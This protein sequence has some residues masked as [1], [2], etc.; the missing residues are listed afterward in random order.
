[1]PTSTWMP[2]T[3]ESTMLTSRI[4][5]SVLARNGDQIVSFLKQNFPQLVG[6]LDAASILNLAMTTSPEAVLALVT[7]GDIQVSAN[8]VFKS[9]GLKNFT[10]TDAQAEVIH[11]A[12]GASI[13]IVDRLV[14]V[15]FDAPNTVMMPIQG[16]H[17]PLMIGEY[18]IRAM[19]IDTL[20]NVGSYAEPT[21]LRVVMPEA[22][23][24]SV[25]AASIGDRNGD[26]DADEPYESGTIYSNTTDGVMLTITVDH[27]SPHPA[28]IWAEYRG[29]DRA[30]HPIGEAEMFDEGVGED[31]STFEV[32]WDVT[33]FEALVSAG[34]SVMVRAVS[35][36]ALEIPYASEPFSIKLDAGVHP[37]DLEVLAVV[38]DT[39]SITKTNPDSG[40]P[41]GTV[42]IN[43]YTPQRT[44]PEIASLKLMIDDEVVG[45]ADTGVLATEEEIAALQ[46]N[47]DFITDLVAVA[48]EATA[49]DEL[50][51]KP[52]HYPTYLKWSVEVDTT[53]LEDTITAESAAARDASKD[54]NQYMV[55]A[56][57]ITSGAEEVPGRPGAKTYLSVDNVDDVAP[58]GPTTIVAVADVAG[59]IEADADGNY[60]VGG[61]VD[62]TVPTPIAIYT[63]EPTADP[64]TY[65]SIQLVQVDA[66]GNE[67][68]IDGEAGM[69]DITTDVGVLENGAYMLH[70]L[71]VDEF[72]NVQT[73]ES[74][75][76]TVHVLNFRVSD[77]T[78]LKVTAVDSVDV[79]RTPQ[80]P[81][82]LRSS[83]TVGF[84]V[85]NGSLD[86]AELS[87]SVDGS[88]VPTESD[89]DP[90]NTFSLMVNVS[91]LAD[92]MYTPNAVVTK[93]N[94]SVGFPLKEINLDNTGPMVEIQTPSED[95]TVDSLPT[96]HATYTDGEGSG[97]DST[98]KEVLAWATTELPAGPTVG[99]TRIL[100]EQGDI[101]VAVDQRAIETDNGT[102]VYTR[103]EKLG[104]GAYRITVRVADIL[105]NVGEATREFA[106]RRHS[107]RHDT[108]SHH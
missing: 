101:D 49:M 20:F 67:T 46:Q 97:T 25:T 74:P 27:R 104:G 48:A 23:K 7:P 57:A 73:D 5:T 79:P 45:T 59:M 108:A 78:Q 71:A 80:E 72:G 6:G 35:K 47:T 8:S 30:W 85:D 77:V 63:T 34:D 12:L 69:L 19:G 33:D 87:G 37:V 62:E 36:N 64:S 90:E 18:G 66:D 82:P 31:G 53:A 96:V 9:L 100:P 83:L 94:G 106:I 50:S 105:G 13:D 3:I 88:E 107:G 32:N 39:E 14:P 4:W 103:T 17:M 60:T 42:V 10:L 51:G 11:Q 26:G 41:Q 81:I 55:N 93:R 15:T 65:A 92:G 86:A 54:D 16:A 29:A 61:I 95:H 75:Q 1:M 91:E 24:A 98:G 21:R 40:G 2:L 68:M 76:I 84:N 38:L 22:D 89:E 44:Y 102:L 56:T 43:G 99:I 52:I 58:L 28:S 70:A